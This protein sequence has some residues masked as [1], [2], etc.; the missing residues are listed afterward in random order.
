MLK[1]TTQLL[2]GV[3]EVGRGCLFGPVVAC[4]V[5]LSD[6]TSHNLMQLGL[7]DSK[8]LRPH[9]R[10]TLSQQIQAVALDYKLG[11]AS[12]AEIDR[13]N[14]LQATLL[15]MKRAVLKLEPT[16][17]LCLIDGNQPLHNLH[18]QQKTVV[19]GDRHQTSNAA[20]R[21]VCK[22]LGA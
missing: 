19:G 17:N 12:V 20:A 21:I 13:L 11:L 7:T 1:Q 5:I 9:Q 22:V 16:P 15:A 8:L 14:I 18:I 6:Q 2:A 3:D 4:A 10:Q